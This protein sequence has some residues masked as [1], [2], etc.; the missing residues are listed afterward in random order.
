VRSFSSR[1]ACKNSYGTT[2]IS[3]EYRCLLACCGMLSFHFK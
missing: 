2:W 3:W 1:G